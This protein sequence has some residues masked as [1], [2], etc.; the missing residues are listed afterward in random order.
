MSK[1]VK[2]IIVGGLAIFGGYCAYK[3]F[4]ANKAR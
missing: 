3:R 1:D 2:V 4:V